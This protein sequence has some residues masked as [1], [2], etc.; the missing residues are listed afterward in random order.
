[1]PAFTF[2]QGNSRGVEPYSEENGGRTGA[3]IQVVSQNG[4]NDFHGSAFFKY[5][6]PILNAHQ[7]WGGPHGEAPRRVL[8]KVETDRS[9]PCLRPCHPP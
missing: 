5:N 1:M 8:A 3:V 6:D 2:H 9:S 7:Q 4:T